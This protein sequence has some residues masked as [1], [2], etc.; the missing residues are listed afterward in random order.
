MSWITVDSER[1]FIHGQPVR[2]WAPLIST[3][4]GRWEFCLPGGSW[5]CGL[6]LGQASLQG[7]RQHGEEA[8]EHG[9]PQS[10]GPSEAASPCPGQSTCRSLV[11]QKSGSSS[12]LR[13]SAPGS[14]SQRPSPELYC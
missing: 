4:L 1:L 8:W 12:I 2:Q 10:V 7:S 5:L 11:P 14:Q 6:S 3:D 13:F 9:P